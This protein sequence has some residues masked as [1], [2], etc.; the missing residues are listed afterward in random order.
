MLWLKAHAREKAMKITKHA[1]STAF[2]EKMSLN[3]DSKENV[4]GLPLLFEVKAMAGTEE[5]VLEAGLHRRSNRLCKTSHLRP[6]TKRAFL[7]TSAVAIT[8]V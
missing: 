3:L 5:S 7:A 8:L 4:C 1:I 2:G 6:R